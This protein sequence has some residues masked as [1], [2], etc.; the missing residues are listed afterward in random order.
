MI[1]IEPPTLHYKS[2]TQEYTIYPLGDLHLGPK[3]C[4]EKKLREDVK[5]IAKDKYGIVYGMGD[6]F[7][8][9]TRN[10]KR[11]DSRDISDWVQADEIDEVVD[12]QIERGIEILSPIADKFMLLIE[13]NHESK[14]RRINGTN[15]TRRL[16]K[17]LSKVC[18][19]NIPYCG[20]AAFVRQRFSRGGAVTQII[21][22]LHHGWFAGRKKGGKINNMDDALNRFRCDLF[23]CAHAHDRLVTPGT[24]IG[25]GQ[26]EN[27]IKEHRRFAVMTGSYL[28][29]YP[30]GAGGYGEDFGYPPTDIGYVPI[31]VT[32]DK[33]L[34]KVTI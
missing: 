20:K 14:M 31:T 10:D 25:I 27:K 3:A 28:K 16:A 18:G 30:D 15:P 21:S 33:R 22:C 7:D 8:C 19:R 13:G 5:T 34:I 9:I 12:L 4:W 29:T 26:K 11:F 1:V 6:Y 17:A 2:R 24:Q 23:I 32:P